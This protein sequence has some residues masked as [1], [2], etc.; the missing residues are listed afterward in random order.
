MGTRVGRL[1]AGLGVVGCGLLLLGGCATGTA[2]ATAET[3]TVTVPA[4][5]S[6]SPSPGAASDGAASDGAA[7]DGASS[8]STGAL[9]PPNCPTG[10]LGIRLGAAEGAAGSTVT[11]LVF[12]NTGSSTC[13]LRGFPGVSFVAGDDGHQVGPAAAEDGARAGQ[14][15]LAP[16]TSAHA[17]VR[18]AD[19]GN[20]DNATCVPT[21]VRGL[22][23]Y[24]PDDTAAAF[25]P[26]PQ[27]ACAHTL[28][29]HVET[30]ESGA[31]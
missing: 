1:V 25:V 17:L 26:A 31:S 30:M 7:S 3:T 14:V 16:G 10:Q 21:A 23:V 15:D 12:T 5:T 29:L 27:T 11:P 2:P 24:P 9:T 8:G 6:V 4:S 28:L 22:R 13:Q 20:Y 19:S 18:V